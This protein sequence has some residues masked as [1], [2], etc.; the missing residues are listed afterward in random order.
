MQYRQIQCREHG[1]TFS[2]PVKR[3]RPPVKCSPENV[4]DM[5]TSSARKARTAARQQSAKGAAAAIAR[6]LKGATPKASGGRRPAKVASARE[7][8]EAAN[9]L[10]PPKRRS[11]KAPEASPVVVRHNPSIVLAKKAKDQLEP[12]GWVCKGR[13]WFGEDGI[14]D[15]QGDFVELG[16]AELIARRGDELLMIV[17]QDGK[18]VSQDYS[19]W[20]PD[21]AP[22]ANGKPK[23]RL[24]FNPDEMSDTELVTELMGKQVEWWNKTKQGK[25]KATVSPKQVRIE[26]VFYSPNEDDEDEKLRNREPL[27]MVTFVDPS[28]GGYRTFHVEA[29]MKVSR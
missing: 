9:A 23:T 2:V 10:T 14:T 13:A 5:A 7:Q 16:M 1:G 8:R 18:P 11:R 19:L 26:H 15:E 12:L 4:C 24:P 6:T 20:N 21:R 27:R 29:L 25:E 28:G 22:T 17:W 3:G